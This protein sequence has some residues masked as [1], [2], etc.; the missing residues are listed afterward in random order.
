M[1]LPKSDASPLAGRRILVVED[2]SVIASKIGQVLDRAGAEVAGPIPTLRAALK[3]IDKGPPIDAALIDVDLRG[4]PAF[5]LC[6]LL[7]E[8]GTKFMLLTGY[9]LEALPAPWSGSMAIQKPFQSD[10]LI[11]AVLALLATPAPGRAT[12]EEAP[13]ANMAERRW[14]ESVREGRNVIMESHILIEDSQRF[15][16]RRRKGG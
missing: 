2:M 11:R 1:S 6:E 3:A 10:D 13:P 15:R 8:R 14:N 4:E 7:S 9:E 5:P 12:T 16:A